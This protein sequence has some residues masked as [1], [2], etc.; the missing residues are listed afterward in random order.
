MYVIRYAKLTLTQS[1]T[2][3]SFSTVTTSL[4]KRNTSMR[5][6]WWLTKQ[7]PLWDMNGDLLNKQIPLWDVNGDLLNKYPYE[8]EW[9]LTKQKNTS[10]RCEWWLTKQIPLG[11]MN[12]DL[13]N[14]QIPL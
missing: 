5:Y 6:E 9:W 4:V 11:D 1:Q 10:M 3:S 14:K 2:F 13:L 12:G 7:I 8:Y